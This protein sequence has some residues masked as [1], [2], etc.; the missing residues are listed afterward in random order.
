VDTSKGEDTVALKK[1][2]IGGR[3]LTSGESSFQDALQRGVEGETAF[4]PQQLERQKM[5]S[6]DGRVSTM[7]I[8]DWTALQDHMAS[9]RPMRS[10]YVRQYLRDQGYDPDNMFRVERST[11][12]MLAEH[13]L[14][15]MKTDRTTLGRTDDLHRLSSQMLNN[16]QNLFHSVENSRHPDNVA[17]LETVNEIVKGGFRLERPQGSSWNHFLRFMRDV[18][19]E[20]NAESRREA[21]SLFRNI[22]HVVPL[23]I[24]HDW[25]AVV[26]PSTGEIVLPFSCTAFEMRA[27]GLRVILLCEE[28]T[29]STEMRARLIIGVNRNWYMNATT[30]RIVGDR[31][32]PIDNSQPLEKGLAGRF[33]LQIWAEVRAACIILEA[34]VGETEE[35]K[36][37]HSPKKTREMARSGA[38]PVTHRVIMLARRHR[39]TREEHEAGARG[40]GVKC[41]FRIGHWRH[42]ANGDSGRERYQDDDGTPRSRTRIAWQIIGDPKLGFIDHTYR[43]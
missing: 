20:M 9:P 4:F 5:F 6:L 16:S 7:I 17:D 11:R 35:R 36:Q 2:T 34:G 26:P 21:D 28:A 31:I 38:P 29:T 3:G 15:K 1:T 33:I 12:I 27:S 25:A 41:H 13:I 22:K 23:V 18:G 39:R 14:R 10:D 43:L 19:S 37:T 24:E 40:P 30:F 8:E 42:F 32:E